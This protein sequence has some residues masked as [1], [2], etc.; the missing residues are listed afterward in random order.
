MTDF[1]SPVQWLPD[2]TPHNR[3]FNDR[4]R[5]D[6]DHGRGGILQARHVFLGGCGLPDAWRAVPR[7]TLLETG[8]G[9]GLNFLAT[10]QA[11]RA[12]PQAPRVLHYVAIDAWP[13]TADDLQRGVAPYPELAPLAHELAGRWAGLLPGFHRL[14]FDE[15]RVLLTLCIGEVRAMLRELRFESDSVYLDGFTPALNPDM[16]APHTLKAVSHLCRRGTRVATWTI[17]RSVR[18]ALAQNGFLVE[19]APGLPPKRD[20]LRAT[21]DPPWNPRRPEPAPVAPW[22][23]GDR[24][25]FVI[26]AGLAGASAAYS[27]AQRGW[28]VIVLDR[29]P[30]PAAGASGLPAGVVAPHVSP[31]DRLLSQ[32]SRSGVSAT[33]ARAADLLPEGLDWA[34]SGVLE[35]RLKD[36]RELPADW[37]APGSPGHAWSRAADAAQ[38]SA[39]TLGD[40]SPAHWHARGGWV[41]APALVA[42]MLAAPGISWRGHAAVAALRQEVSPAEDDWPHA[43]GWTALAADGTV[44]AQAPVVVVAAGFDSLDLLASTGAPALP[45]NPLRGQLLYGPMPAPP[46]PLPPF[47]VNGL[48]NFITDV[49]VD[50]VPSW[51]LGSTFERGCREAVLRDADTQE[52]A[53]KLAVLLPASAAALAPQIASGAARAWAAVRC[54]VPDRLP[55]VGAVDAAGL[56]GLFV[57]TGMGAR[58][59]TLAVLCGELLAAQLAGEPLPV[60]LRHARALAPQRLLRPG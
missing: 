46:H 10:W 30:S 7:W 34:A 42:A 32:L 23:G 13:P 31:D 52:V 21:W 15:G 2:G 18:D 37:L 29:A 45:L 50:G 4:Y 8:F 12:D 3:R 58:G 28:Q 1:A 16:W 57:S 56:P 22:L 20:C 53:A 5:G 26:G 14:A 41:R 35:R 24:R 59:M 25:A 9:L 44:L 48:G 27:L 36:S 19:K 40:D 55:V 6:G 60:P 49:P 54:T 33:L 11:W 51:V 47:P 17:A 43:K 39:A 38:R